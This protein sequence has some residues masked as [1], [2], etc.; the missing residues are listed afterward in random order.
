MTIKYPKTKK[1][2]KFQIRQ[3]FLILKNF[4]KIIKYN[5][6]LDEMLDIE[7]RLYNKRV[8]GGSGN[9]A[10]KSSRIFLDTETGATENVFSDEYDVEVDLTS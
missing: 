6:Y 3:K 2:R 8:K 7:R 10:P 4:Y 9:Y 1:Q 5:N